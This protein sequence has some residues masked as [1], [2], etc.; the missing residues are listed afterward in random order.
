MSDEDCI[1]Q[2]LELAKQGLALTSPG[3]MV[4]A[5]IVK[6][7][8]IVGEGFY[9]YDGVR[10]AEVIALEQAGEAARGATV[11]TN[12]EP[13]SH[14]GRTSPCARALIDAGVKRVV[15]AMS[16]PNPAVNGDGIK[17]LRASGIEVETG[18]LEDEARR[19]N[20]AFVTYKLHN[21]PFGI[22]KIAMTLDGKIATKSG[23]S[24][25]IT[26]EASREMVQELRHRVDAVVTGSGSVL[27][28]RPQLTDRTGL[29][30]RRPLLPVILDRRKRVEDFPGALLFGG[31]LSELT[32]TL[33]AMEIQSFLME[34]G[35]DLAF[36]AL[37]A[38]IIDKLVVFLAPKILG[39]REI[40]AI[41]GQGIE[42]LSDAVPLTDWSVTQCGPDI[43]I[44]AYVYRNH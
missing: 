36:S 11:Y 30:R 23:E 15:T 38:G 9:T 29:P 20:E 41:G 39:G 17:M 18:I 21:R 19:L 6:D 31:S 43:V 25:W 27:A 26:S 2:T 40:P 24:K 1:R 10:H 44:T 4:G 14:Y 12:L 7:G 33:Q 42:R 35:P 13:C 8:R 16:D 34:C 28:D 32:T 5:V 37:R 3:V 22:L